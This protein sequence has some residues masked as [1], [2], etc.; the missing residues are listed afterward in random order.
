EI[1]AHGQR[2]SIRAQPHLRAINVAVA[3]IENISVLIVKTVALHVADEGQPDRRLIV[4][5]VGA[6]GADRFGH[7]AGPRKHLGDNAFVDTVAAVDEQKPAHRLAVAAFFPQ[8]DDAR[9]ALLHARRNA[10]LPRGKARLCNG[11]GRKTGAQKN[12]RQTYFHFLLRAAGCANA[13]S[14]NMAV[15][16][17]QKGVAENPVKGVADKPITWNHGTGFAFRP[18][19][20]SAHVESE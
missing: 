11:R 9:L 12:C 20:T 16:G 17:I 6:G 19:G 14:Q 10:R 18:P 7:V 1:A 5:V 3:R 8:A 13:S 15:S 4:A 2:L